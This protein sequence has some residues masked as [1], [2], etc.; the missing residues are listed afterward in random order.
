L[1]LRFL[2]VGLGRWVFDRRIFSP[3]KTESQA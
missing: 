3:P 1:G 2:A